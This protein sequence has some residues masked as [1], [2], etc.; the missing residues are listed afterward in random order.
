MKIDNNRILY[1]AKSDGGGV[2]KKITGF[3]NAATRAGYD[4]ELNIEP[5][6]GLSGIQRQIQ[7]MISSDAKYIM[8]RS[9]TRNSIFYIWC[10]IRLRL[11]GKVLII[12]QPSPAF[13]YIK[14]VDFQPRSFMN[15]TAKKLLTYI[16]CPFTFMLANRILQYGEESAYFRFFSG[17]RTLL[18][19][20]GI[21][22]ERM[23][24]REKGYPDGTNQLTLIGVGAN[25]ESWHGFDRVVR[26]MGKWKK[27]GKKPHVTFNIVGANDTAHA[28]M[29]KE[30][31]KQYD[32]EDDVTFWGYLTSE[33]LNNLYNCCSLAVASLG[34]HRKGLSTA[35]VLKVREY[36]LAGIPFI[37][38]GRDPDFP[39]SIP[40]RFV[41][42][43][44]DS[45]DDI[46][47]VFKVFAK[48][49]EKFTDIDIRKYAI[50]HL[51]FDSKIREILSQTSNS[52]KC[53]RS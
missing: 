25:I 2:E 20:N 41:V 28:N 10:F 33:E 39:E 38:A 36:C 18:I 48:Q 50:A 12:D 19:G 1:I 3:C 27:Q 26:A 47:D 6:Y 45:I 16:G 43:N 46:I 7:K 24:L 5:M 17:N 21:D 30:L 8:M 44:D 23:P 34:L 49:R 51:S 42:G 32:I 4:V 14:E 22:T 52:L 37:A 53:H 31:V 15:R 9:P 40:F 11:Q 13:T 29:I 35:S